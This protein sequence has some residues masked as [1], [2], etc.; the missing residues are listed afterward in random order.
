MYLGSSA[1]LSACLNVCLNLLFTLTNE[2]YQSILYGVCKP[3]KKSTYRDG[4][5]ACQS[6][7]R[8]AYPYWDDSYASDGRT[9]YVKHHNDLITTKLL[10]KVSYLFASN[11]LI[12]SYR[13]VVSNS[14]AVTISCD[15]TYLCMFYKITMISRV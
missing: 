14:K 4:V 11:F 9:M 8:L 10:V 6:F 13:Q 1:D 2:C 12:L 5:P 7:R 3:G 15:S